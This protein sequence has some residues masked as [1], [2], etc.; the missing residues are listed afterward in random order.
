M[1]LVLSLVLFLLS[2]P[3]GAF[4][5]ND[6]KA[7]INDLSQQTA[8]NGNSSQASGLAQFT[9]REQIESL[10]QA[11]SQGAETAV[12][13]LARENGYLGNDKVRIPLPDNLQK[14]DS[15]MRRLGLGK[16]SDELVTSMNRAAEAA[17][18]E[19]KALLLTAVKN[20]TVTDAKN[21]L[22][23]KDDA[24][25][26][27]FRRNTETALGEKFKPV[28]SQSMQKV[29]LAQAYERF[30][31]KGVKLGLIDASDADLEDYITRKALDGLFYMMAEQEKEIRAHPVQAVGDLAKKVF[32]AVRGQ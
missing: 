14:A 10:R 16:Y 24:A 19:A 32:S 15:T 31:G 18:P 6:L 29:S 23:G 9:E 2:A 8:S 30:A 11:L 26:Q 7:K 20:M 4:D 3:A 13:N 27:Y 25:T 17:V 5:L 12:S 1:R 28:V 21:I 22:L